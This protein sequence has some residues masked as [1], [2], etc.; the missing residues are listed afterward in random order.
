MVRVSDDGIGI[1]PELLPA[2]FDLFAHPQHAFESAGGGLR[3]GLYLN[4]CNRLAALH[5][6]ELSASSAGINCGSCFTLRLPL[7]V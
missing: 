7:H 5:G 1:A 4:R 6:G 3:L 2:L